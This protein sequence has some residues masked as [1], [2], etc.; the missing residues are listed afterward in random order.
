MKKLIFI[1]LILF[2]TPVYANMTYVEISNMCYEKA[3]QIYW[4]CVDKAKT[5]DDLIVCK[6]K[7]EA[8]AD[9]CIYQ[10]KQKQGS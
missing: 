1:T 8:N 4:E 7:R 6:A 5:S 2:S 10:E 9:R 3:N